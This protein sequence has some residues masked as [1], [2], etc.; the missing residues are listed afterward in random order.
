MAGL[1]NPTPD[2]SRAIAEVEATGKGTYPYSFHTFLEMI[3]AFQFISSP[4]T[5]ITFN[6]FHLFIDADEHPADNLTT[7]AALD[8]NNLLTKTADISKGVLF[9]V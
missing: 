4:N 1:K 7:V 2:I 9:N 8:I 3:R 5:H 6:V